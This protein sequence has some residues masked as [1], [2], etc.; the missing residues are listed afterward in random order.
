MT[1]MNKLSVS[2]FA[3]TLAATSAL[4]ADC[5]TCRSISDQA[6]Y[7]A[8]MK[9]CLAGEAPAVEKPAAQTTQRDALAQKAAAYDWTNESAH[10]TVT[11]VTT[12][13]A[14][15]ASVEPLKIAEQSVTVT[16]AFIAD[17]KG[18]GGLYLKLPDLSGMKG[19][20]FLSVFD[21]LAVTAVF[22]S[23]VTARVD[24][25]TAVELPVQMTS[26]GVYLKGSEA[27][28]A[29]MTQGG[30]LTVRLSGSVTEA[31]DLYFDLRGF[32]EAAQ[33]VQLGVGGIKEAPAADASAD[34][35]GELKSLFNDFLN[36]IPSEGES[37]KSESSAPAA[38]SS[39]SG[40]DQLM[41]F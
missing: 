22:G 14:A 19:V 15:K 31:T 34:A 21:N 11:D 37:P 35:L 9:S 24:K 18:A 41:K 38:P 8:C 2:I 28:L 12:V 7:L 20:P 6:K 30:L 25:E 32:T 16:L 10:D 4:A 39:S 23:S 40:E 36:L 33:W 26:G 29:Q 1:S 5:S 13:S 27:L 17:T 3:L